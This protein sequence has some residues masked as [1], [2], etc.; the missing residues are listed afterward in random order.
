M[1]NNKIEI[2][3]K[4][5]VE[6]FESFKKLNETSPG[7]YWAKTGK[8]QKEY[9]EMYDEL[10]PNEGPAETVKG[11]LIRAVSRLYYEEY[12]NGNTNARD[13]NYDHRYDEDDD[14]YEEPEIMLNEFYASF[15]GLIRQYVPNAHKELDEIKNYI[16][17]GED[18]FDMSMESVY[19]SLVD[20][21]V[22]FCMSGAPS[23]EE[24]TINKR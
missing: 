13:Y 19:D 4:P 21:V 15:I 11:E 24:K 10:V 20:K 8:Y 14:E 2:K 5:I 17:S 16:L 23:L 1:K 22:E 12:N 3:D 18:S 6:S 7:S 9:E